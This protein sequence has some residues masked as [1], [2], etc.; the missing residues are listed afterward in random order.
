MERRLCI[1]CEREFKMCV[2]KAECLSGVG[3]VE[4]S[5]LVQVDPG[6]SLGRQAVS[7]LIRAGISMTLLVLEL[8]EA[9]LHPSPSLALL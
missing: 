3:L 1:K 2:F 4:W 9:T 5:V 6:D 7:P 8:S